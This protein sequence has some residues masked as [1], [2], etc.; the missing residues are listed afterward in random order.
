M[1]LLLSNF[2]N[3]T[4]KEKN[5]FKSNINNTIKKAKKRLLKDKVLEDKDL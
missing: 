5:N 4:F 2:L 3:L 1:S